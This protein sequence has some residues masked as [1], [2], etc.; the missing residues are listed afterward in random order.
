MAPPPP[1]GALSLLTG[2]LTN[3]K[4]LNLSYTKVSDAGCTTLA[5]ALDG[6]AL[7]ALG[8]IQFEGNRAKA[9][10]N[11]ALTKSR[12]AVFAI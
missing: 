12:A 11:E 10:V 3:L 1:A 6:G 4:L 7:P 9:A 5:S 8:I 2:E